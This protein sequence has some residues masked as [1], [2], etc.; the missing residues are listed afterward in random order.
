MEEPIT[1]AECAE[2]LVKD[3]K[4][5][6]EICLKFGLDDYCNECNWEHYCVLV[7]EWEFA[8]NNV[9]KGKII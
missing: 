2:E 8:R 7:K 6:Q 4:K 5:Q 3:F 9:R 1:L